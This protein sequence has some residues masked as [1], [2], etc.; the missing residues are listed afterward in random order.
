MAKIVLPALFLA[1]VGVCGSAQADQP[2][3]HSQPLG[4]A[5]ANASPGS[6][7]ACKSQDPT[8]V[9]VCGRSQ[10]RYRIDPDVLA[11]TRAAEAP[12]PKPRLDATNQACVGPDCGGATIPLVRMGL[13][14]IRAAEL[15]ANGDDWRDAFR[16][17]PDAYRAY[18]ESKAKEAE[19]KGRISV[20]VTAG[21]GSVPK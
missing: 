12:P 13:T 8:E 18:E 2:P 17:H 19:K 15:A 10:E 6:A 16:T 20:G 14:I 1:A 11:A 9:V 7:N 3:A 4:E 21:T 5:I